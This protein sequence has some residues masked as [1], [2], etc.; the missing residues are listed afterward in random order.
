MMESDESLVLRIGAFLLIA[1]I[2]SCSNDLTQKECTNNSDCVI[3]YQCVNHKCVRD[4]T[5]VVCKTDEDCSDSS[6]KCIG[7]FCQ[8][9]SSGCK[10]DRDCPSGYRCNT[11]NKSCE[12]VSVFD[13]GR[14]ISD[15]KDADD[16]RP[17]RICESDFNCDIPEPYCRNN[18]CVSCVIIGCENNMVCNEETGLCN[19]VRPDAGVADL[20]S[21]DGIISDESSFDS[22]RG[23]MDI[24]CN[25]DMYCD[26]NTLTCVPGCQYDTDCCVGKC[27]NG[28]CES[29]NI[30]FNNNDCA[31]NP[32]NKYCEIQSGVCVECLEDYQ[33]KYST[34]DKSTYKCNPVEPGTIGDVCNDIEFKCQSGQFCIKESDGTGFIGGYC[35]K[36]CTSFDNCPYDWENNVSSLC[37][38]VAS[39]PTKRW[40][41]KECNSNSECRSEYVCY[42]LN[43]FEGV[44]WPRCDNP[45]RKCPGGYVCNVQT[46]L[47]EGTQD[48]GQPC[49]GTYNYCKKGLICA[50]PPNGQAYCYEACDHFVDAFCKDNSICVELDSE[51][52][53]CDFGGDVPAG[54][55]CTY[56]D[57]K[58]GLVCLGNSISGYKCYYACDRLDN[59][60]KC[61]AGKTCASIEG[62]IQLGYCK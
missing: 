60:P 18:V 5:L 11:S 4:N 40:C 53:I 20:V 52:S 25:C 29:A 55:D 19:R 38:Q 54:G 24:G 22:G 42:P 8:Y 41:L 50:G 44:C 1:F 45:G 39:N 46:G 62:E 3:G 61:P 31:S 12:P 56:S 59:N 9:P 14:D 35:S 21:S 28:K 51:T 6:M 10:S 36:D 16:A 15:E 49:G 47:C 13:G 30:C 23:C 43:S 37:V 32:K 17:T 33:C 48:V 26:S 58:K 2:F 27:V 34:C 7:G 57:C